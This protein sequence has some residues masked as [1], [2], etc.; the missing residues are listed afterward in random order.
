LGLQVHEESPGNAEAFAEM[1]F[2]KL[3][4]TQLGDHEVDPSVRED[5]FFIKETLGIC[6][7]A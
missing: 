3:P 2:Q 5:S 4:K 7:I 6:R 1:I